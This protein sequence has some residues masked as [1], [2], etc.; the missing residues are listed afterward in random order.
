M[1]VQPDRSLNFPSVDRIRTKLSHAS[2]LISG[3]T[4]AD[5]FVCGHVSSNIDGPTALKG[6]LDQ[7]SA[8]ALPTIPL[9]IIFDLQRVVSMDFTVAKAVTALAKSIS[10]AGQMVRFCGAGSAVADVLRGVDS[11]VLSYVDVDDAV[12]SILT[13]TS[14]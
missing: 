13:T 3:K 8:T 5:G 4:S 14:P 6:A 1:L 9:P 12:R 10:S 2:S 7:H 11:S